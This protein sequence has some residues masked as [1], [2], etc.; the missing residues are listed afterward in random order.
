MFK[1]QIPSG[2]VLG[3]GKYLV[4]WADEDGGETGLHA[5]FK[6]SA[7]GESIT[8]VYRNVLVDKVEFGVQKS[9]VSSGPL[10]DM[11]GPWKELT[12]TPGAANRPLK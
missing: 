10:G 11:R 8:L 5:N 2:T 12:P 7:K 4:I 1:W 6:L 3:A 9:D